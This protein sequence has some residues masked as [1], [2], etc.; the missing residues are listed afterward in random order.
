MQKKCKQKCK[1]KAPVRASRAAQVT[2]VRSFLLSPDAQVKRIPRNRAA[3]ATCVR[4]LPIA[5]CCLLVRPHAYQP[6][7]LSFLEGSASEAT[8]RN[9]APQATCVYDLPLPPD[10]NQPR[11]AIIAPARAITHV[12]SIL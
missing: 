12:H 4:G 9:R 5:S 11:R 6:R 7:R 1:K 3:Q 2:C 10:A 8:P